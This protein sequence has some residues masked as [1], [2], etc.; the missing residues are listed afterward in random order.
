MLMNI[1]YTKKIYKMDCSSSL[2][3]IS[4]DLLKTKNFSDVPIE[5]VEIFSNGRR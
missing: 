2:T 5:L 1:F 4:L 3:S